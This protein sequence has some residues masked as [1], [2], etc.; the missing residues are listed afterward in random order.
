MPQISIHWPKGKAKF[1]T[2]VYDFL[3]DSFTCMYFRFFLLNI[4]QKKH[5]IL[6]VH[7]AQ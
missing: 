4:F 1:Q 6:F 5:L 2:H 7:T 3:L